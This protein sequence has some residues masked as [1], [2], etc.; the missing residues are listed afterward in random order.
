MLLL[1]LVLLKDMFVFY[2]IDIHVLYYPYK[3]YRINNISINIANYKIII[4]YV[5]EQAEIMCSCIYFLFLIF[6][7][8]LLFL[9][10]SELFI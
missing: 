2:N 3:V 6:K 1:K 4:E 10:V 5:N 7:G 8:F 9:E